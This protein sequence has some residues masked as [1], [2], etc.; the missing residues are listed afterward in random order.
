MGVPIGHSRQEA[1]HHSDFISNQPK[2]KLTKVGDELTPV[3][4]GPV[5]DAELTAWHAAGHAHF[6]SERLTRIMWEKMPPSPGWK[7]VNK[8]EFGQGFLKGQNKSEVPEG[9]ISA[10][11]PRRVVVGQQTEAWRYILLTNWMG[12]DGFLWKFSARIP[13]DEHARRYN[14]EQRQGNK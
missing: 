5:N 4:R 3:V 9:N 8:W 10:A 14:L 2:A 12:D 6:I 1:T 7:G 11:H 13:E